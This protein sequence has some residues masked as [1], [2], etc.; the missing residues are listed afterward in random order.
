MTINV[1]IVGSHGLYA[2]YGGWDQLVINLAELKTDNFSYVIYN[3]K[4]TPVTEGIN[5]V[6]VKQIPLSGSGAQGLVFDSLSIFS[7]FYADVILMLGLKAMP[8]A[9][10]IKLIRPKI[11]LVINIGGV[12]WERPQFNTLFKGYLRL[13]FYL[14]KNTSCQIIIDNNYYRNF[15]G[16]NEQQKIKQISYGGMIDQTFNKTDVNAEFAFVE[17]DYYLS[18]SR[19]IIDNKLE[20][21]CDLFS[22]LPEKNLVLISNFSNS[23]YGRYVLE[24]YS[25]YTNIELIDGLYDKPKLDVVRRSCKAYIHTHTLCGSAPSLI[26]M[27]VCRVPIYS[28]NVTQNRHTLADQGFYFDDFNELEVMLEHRPLP[29]APTAEFAGVYDWHK[30]VREYEK[31]FAKAGTV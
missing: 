4:E 7:S 1:N 2:S 18:I 27:I 28:I 19:S 10:L 24:R 8:V 30:V 21:L 6:T 20:E 29:N 22:K 5:G 12:E 16:A 3:P 9:A 11:K 23:S 15:F 14:A 17:T 13:C 31:L 26:E 25:V